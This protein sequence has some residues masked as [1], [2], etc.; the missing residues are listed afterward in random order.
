MS[1]NIVFKSRKRYVAGHKNRWTF[2]VTGFLQLS[3]NDLYIIGAFIIFFGIQFLELVFR[4]ILSKRLA[5]E[6]VDKRYEVK[7]I[8]FYLPILSPQN[9]NSFFDYASF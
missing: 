7:F 2:M 8:V 9:I 4:V 3:L 1:V 5:K 6:E